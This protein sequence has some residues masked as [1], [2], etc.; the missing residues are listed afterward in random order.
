METARSSSSK[1]RGTSY[2]YQP[3][4]PEA[5]TIRLISLQ[6]APRFNS[7]I[8]CDLYHVALETK[9][10]Y[11]AI[12]YSW[13]DPNVTS[14]IFL[15]GLPFQVTV[16]LMSA[17]RHLR[18]QNR[19][20]TLWVD[21]IC[22]DQANLEE[23]GHQVAFMAKIYSMAKRDLLW[24]GDDPNE[25]ACDVFKYVH[26]MAGICENIPPDGRS[27][28]KALRAAASAV[29]KEA[30]ASKLLRIL[31]NR[32]VW[33]RIWVVQEIAVSQAIW[34]HCGFQSMKW[35]SLTIFC[36]LLKMLRWHFVRD[37]DGL[38]VFVDV[39][40]A[41]SPANQIQRVRT[42]YSQPGI[43]LDI[44][45]L[46]SQLS[47]FEATNPRDK[48]FALLGLIT[49]LDFKPDY[50]K[51]VSDI[52]AMIVRLSILNSKRLRALFFAHKVLTVKEQG[53]I[54]LP[55][56]V[57]DFSSSSYDGA[58]LIMV[59]IPYSACGE[60]V[61]LPDT[62]NHQATNSAMLVVFG[63]QLDKVS[64]T[65]RVA[66]EEGIKGFHTW[67]S[68]RSMILDLP[69]NILKN[70]YHTGESMLAATARTLTGDISFG[71][72]LQ[73]QSKEETRS[74]SRDLEWVS[75]WKRQLHSMLRSLSPSVAQSLIPDRLKRREVQNPLIVSHVPCFPGYRLSITSQN[76]V[77]M[78][79]E[80]SEEG[81]ILCILYGSSFPHV[82][83][84]V[85]GKED[86][87]TLVGSA[88]VH[89]FMDGEAIELRDQG[90]LKEQRFNLI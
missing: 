21:A 35:D 44:L 83:R 15:Q 4:D 62:I 61:V 53:N 48:I 63:L 81:D 69:S 30:P 64:K 59:D 39:I 80:T 74:I 89:G 77:A 20:R 47:E 57:P 19:A 12:S 55:T 79:P 67:N 13:G 31:S 87:Y 3:L 38:K 46:W 70:R 41:V 54:N 60:A 85:A 8:Q 10:Q 71:E 65:Y 76:F 58:F 14:T 23:R 18:D 9:P 86:T 16:N 36:E 66:R 43:K 26:N 32:P 34:I 56:W 5:Q 24:L 37:P 25:E 2:T 6:P 11:E 51:P 45:E 27:K 52:F 78:V 17:L 72:T 50:T 40:V 7:A 75:S 33:G 1:H 49:I 42:Q 84:K 68:L 22:I 88:Y 28:R 82:L 29:V 90:R 73:R